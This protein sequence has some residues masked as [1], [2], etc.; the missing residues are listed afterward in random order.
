MGGE[1]LQILHQPMT[2]SGLWNDFVN[3]RKEIDERGKVT[4]DLFVLCL[5][6]L[7]TIRAVKFE[8]GILSKG[9]LA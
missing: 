5:D 1:L 4:F 7:F 3:Y 9:S 6:F 2:V 8:E